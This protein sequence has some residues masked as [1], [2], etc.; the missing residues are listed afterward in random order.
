MRQ[1][2]LELARQAHRNGWLQLAFVE[3]NGEKAAGY[4]NFDYQNHIWVYNSGFD[5][6]FRDLPQKLQ[7]AQ[8]LEETII[9]GG[10]GMSSA[11][12][13]MILTPGNVNR[14]QFFT[15]N[16]RFHMRLLAIADNRWTQT[17]VQNNGAGLWNDSA[18]APYSARLNPNAAVG[19]VK[20]VR[21]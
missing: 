2:M 14:E 13:T 1:Q 3:V 10:S 21:E 9:L 12:A 16:E 19:S 4:M 11:A 15:I 8:K 5:P 7:R 18:T 17:D 20:S 6:K